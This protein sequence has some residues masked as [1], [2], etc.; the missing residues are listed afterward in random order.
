MT[1]SCVLASILKRE[2]RPARTVPFKELAL[3]LALLV[4]SALA[5]AP[6]RAAEELPFC[7]DCNVLA[8]I[9][10]TYRYFQSSRGIVIPVTVVLDQDRYELGGFRFSS[11]QTF[12]STHEHVALTVPPYWAASFT[13]RWRLLR[14]PWGLVYL[15]LGASFKSQSDALNSTHW[16]FAPQLGVRF[17][18]GSHGQIVELT[19]RHWSNASIRFPNRGQDFATLSFGF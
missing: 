11:T 13:R 7:D 2:R 14:E 17:N 8:G 16:N 10:A 1:Y 18:V 6:L 9:G 4:A 19:L 12:V 15:G 3:A 5:A